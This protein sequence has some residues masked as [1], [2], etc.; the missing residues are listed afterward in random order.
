MR[1]WIER[2]QLVR[3]VW[4]RV[5]P[6]GQVVVTAP[7]WYGERL[8]WRLV[9][10]HR[11]WIERQRR[12]YRAMDRIIIGREELLYRGHVYRFVLRRGLG[13]EVLIYP[14]LR[15][16]ASGANLL[17]SPIQRQWYI[18]EATRLVGRRLRQLAERYGFRFTDFA[19]REYASAWGYCTSD[20]TITFDWRIV[21]VPRFVMD[22]LLL[23]E[24]VH[25]KIPHHG[26][27]FWQQVERLC[28][29]YHKAVHWL[30][31]YGRW[32]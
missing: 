11:E 23:H 5:E 25:T 6:D 21:K 7:P 27:R 31:T 29:A 20:G 19:I 14:R 8:L 28:P 2:Q 13:S 3:R 17:S 30:R 10:R 12:C 15:I 9:E 18:N 26:P 4:I 24:L 1:I 16:I 22:Y 32:I